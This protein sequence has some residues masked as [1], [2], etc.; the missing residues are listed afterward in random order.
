MEGTVLTTE[1]LELIP[2]EPAEID[3]LMDVLSDPEV[4][5]CLTMQRL[6]PDRQN[7]RKK[8]AAYFSDQERNG[9]SHWKIMTKGGEFLGTCGF[10]PV[11]ETSEIE[12]AFMLK[13]THWGK[14]YATEAANILVEWFFEHTYF[15]HLIGFARVGNEAWCRVLEKAGMHFRERCAIRGVQCDLFQVLSPSMQKLVA[16]S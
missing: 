5:E 10:V 7:G 8:M 13:R 6:S 16:N 11:D 3:L 1:R 9:F 2:F 12:M 15:S 14:G 4:N